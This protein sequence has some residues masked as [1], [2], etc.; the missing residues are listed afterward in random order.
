MR[1]LL[2]SCEI[3]PSRIFFFAPEEDPHASSFERSS[4][5]LIETVVVRSRKLSWES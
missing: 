2:S 1:L 5:L 4:I 3:Y